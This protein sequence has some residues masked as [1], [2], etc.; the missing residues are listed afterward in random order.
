MI[1]FKDILS[2][3]R[4]G[5]E[6]NWFKTLHE[7]YNRP[8]WELYDLKH[9]PLEMYNVAKKPSYQVMRR[10]CFQSSIITI[11]SIIRRCSRTCDTGCTP[12]KTPPTTHGS[13]HRTQYMKTE[14]RLRRIPSA[15]LSTTEMFY[16]FILLCVRP[17]D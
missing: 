14:D 6:L 9:D 11:Q 3:T 2:R 10:S 4:E 7:Y 17:D 13:V 8:E 16:A 1:C 15:S 12:G 5:Q